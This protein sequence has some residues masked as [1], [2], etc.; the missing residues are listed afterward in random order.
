[1][2]AYSIFFESLM[3]FLKQFLD[4]LNV[5]DA[6]VVEH[7]YAARSRIWVGKWKLQMHGRDVS[8]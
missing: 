7:K 5:V 4:L 1:M 6:A 2:R 8:K 3:C